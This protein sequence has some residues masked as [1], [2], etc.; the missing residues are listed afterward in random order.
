MQEVR[1]P[2]CNALID[3]IGDDET[4]NGQPISRPG[5]EGYSWEVRNA[6][7]REVVI[8][9]RRHECANP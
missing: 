7:T 2:R 4:T 3:R 1:C 6:A 9:P 8:G 5:Y